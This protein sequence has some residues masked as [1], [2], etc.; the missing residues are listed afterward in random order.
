M[1]GLEI[2]IRSEAAREEGVYSLPAPCTGGGSFLSPA[3]VMRL[4]MTGGVD[5][6]GMWM[7]G[8]VIDWGMWMTGVVDDKRDA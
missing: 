7:T 4:W 5:D 8:G 2:M 6:L 3:P 1:N